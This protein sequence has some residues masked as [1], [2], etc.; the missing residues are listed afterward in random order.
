VL[1]A[2]PPGASDRTCRSAEIE[3]AGWAP[4]LHH[5]LMVRW[6]LKPEGNREWRGNADLFS[7]KLLVA[8]AQNIT[9]AKVG[10]AGTA[11]RLIQRVEIRA[12]ARAYSANWPAGCSQDGH[13]QA[14]MSRHKH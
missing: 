8:W 13:E 14:A 1:T 9:A 6:W 11:E 12:G 2:V 3:S 5:D 4:V 10:K 7:V